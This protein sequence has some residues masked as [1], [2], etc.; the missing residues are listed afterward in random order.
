MLNYQRV[1]LVLHQSG[2]TAYGKVDF[3]HPWMNRIIALMIV[4]TLGI[5]LSV[6]TYLY[7]THKKLEQTERLW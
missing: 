2:L 3:S 7:V 1:K 5:P 4:K 6:L